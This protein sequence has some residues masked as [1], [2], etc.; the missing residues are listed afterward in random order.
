MTN[1]EIVG[2]I[3]TSGIVE[4]IARNIRVTGDYYDDFVQ[5]MYLTLMEYDNGRLN[6][7]FGKGQIKYFTAR[8]CLNNWNSSTSPFY[9]KYKRS[10]AHVDG[11]LDP[12]KLSDRI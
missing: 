9:C 1:Q 6:D 5:E 8:V 11:N 7:I 4:D 10:L 2:L 12:S 3:S